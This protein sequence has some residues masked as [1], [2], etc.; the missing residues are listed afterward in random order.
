MNHS[1]TF[2]G[3][4]KEFFLQAVRALLRKAIVSKFI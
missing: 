4:S 2:D 1:K 3:R